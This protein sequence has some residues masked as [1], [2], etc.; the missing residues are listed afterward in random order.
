[1]VRGERWGRWRWCRAGA[2][3]RRG[4]GAASCPEPPVSMA[5]EGAGLV[6]SRGGGEGGKGSVGT[7]RREARTELKP[8]LEGGEL[9]GEN[10]HDFVWVIRKRLLREL[11]DLVLCSVDGYSENP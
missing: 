7:A 2:T 3:M 11:E 4:V 8:Q 6:P 9:V 10:H 5:T 1:M